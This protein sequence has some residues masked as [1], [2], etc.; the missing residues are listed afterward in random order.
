M[1]RTALPIPAALLVGLALAL[2][3]PATVR[4]DGE[5]HLS[6]Q[7]H[8]FQPDKLEVPAGKKF[9]LLVKNLDS[10]PEEFESHD[11]HREKVVPPGKEIPVYLG[12]LDAKSYHFFG[13]FHQATAQGDMI[14]K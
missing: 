2:T 1:K 3:A 11:L 7:D 8:K 13:D 9:T 14:A 12:P 5:I 10:T 6:I 4:A